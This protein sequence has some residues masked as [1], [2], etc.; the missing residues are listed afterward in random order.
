MCEVWKCV[1]GKQQ[2]QVNSTAAPTHLQSRVADRGPL[3]NTQHCQMYT[4]NFPD[5]GARLVSTMLVWN[6]LS[7]QV[8]ASIT[9]CHVAWFDVPALG[10]LQHVP[11][12]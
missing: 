10:A 3:T 12:S 11:H 6:T 2:P 8:V 1:Q 5:G 9:R 7:L 4:H